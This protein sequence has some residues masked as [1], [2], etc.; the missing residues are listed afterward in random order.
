MRVGERGEDTWLESVP[1]R[2]SPEKL[3]VGKERR[4]REEEVESPPSSSSLLFHH[5]PLTYF[6]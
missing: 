6:L 4:E 5:S 1:I 2:E 3:K